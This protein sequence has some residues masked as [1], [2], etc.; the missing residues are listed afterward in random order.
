M[1][2]MSVLGV[3]NVDV[4]PATTCHAPEDTEIYVDTTRLFQDT[5]LPYVQNAKLGLSVNNTAPL[6]P[7]HFVF[8]DAD[9]GHYTEPAFE[10][11]SSET[12][13]HDNTLDMY[14]SLRNFN[15]LS[16]M[17]IRLFSNMALENMTQSML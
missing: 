7:Q 2:L 9:W 13:D 14:E 4:T 16:L 15:A 8:D 5:L 1:L 6:M 12:W 10:T 3:Y 17:L 11:D